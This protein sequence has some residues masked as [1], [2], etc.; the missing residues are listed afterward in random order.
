MNHFEWKWLRLWLVLFAALN[1]HD[2][3][4]SYVIPHT[5]ICFDRQYTRPNFNKHIS[6]L[7]AHGTQS[8]KHFC[9]CKPDIAGFVVFEC[10]CQ[11][12]EIDFMYERTTMCT[13]AE[14][15]EHLLNGMALQK[16]K[17]NDIQWGTYALAIEKKWRN[18][19]LVCP[20]F[21]AHFIK[22]SVIFINKK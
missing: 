4:F 6:H 22:P 11:F 13:V 3:F 7:F 19:A 17:A 20:N 18:M 10:C 5:L 16:W 8:Y 15:C 21:T 1:K 12:K 14:K 9:R 2:I